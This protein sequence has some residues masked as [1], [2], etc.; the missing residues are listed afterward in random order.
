MTKHLWLAAL[1]ML[2]VVS[3]RAAAPTITIDLSMPVGKVSP[4]LYGLMTEEINHAYDGGLYAELLRNRAFL[5]DPASPV[6]WSAVQGGGAA[7]IALD[8]A[9]A[10]NAAIGTSLRLD[11]TQASAGHPAGVANEGY[12]GIP[13]RPHTSYRASFFA[14][15]AP[16]FTGPLTAT[17]ESEDG[18]TTYATGRVSGL[19]QAWK[20]YDADADDRPRSRRPPRP[21]SC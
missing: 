3:P 7:A 6:H 13:V 12:W 11:V 21:A 15:A 8:P 10:L 9:Q 17:I 4:L 19:T 16:G 20:Q 5:D 1:L 18:R 14:K 2:G